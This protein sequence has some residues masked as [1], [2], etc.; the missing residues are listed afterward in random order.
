MLPSLGVQQVVA[1]KLKHNHADKS[2]I[3]VALHLKSGGPAQESLRYDQIKEVKSIIK[4]KWPSADTPVILLGDF[5][6][7]RHNSEN[8]IYGN[9][10][11]EGYVDP[12]ADLDKKETY[13]MGSG[14]Q[15]FDF[16][17]V[18]DSKKMIEVTNAHVV[19]DPPNIYK[20]SDH[21]PIMCT[22]KLNK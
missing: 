6:S 18:K 21:L 17:L 13:T 5:N 10:L 2:I 1:V 4:K 20:A 15:T 9:L 7:N 14:K 11:S 8:Y 3:A 12:F 22:M 16:I 19:R